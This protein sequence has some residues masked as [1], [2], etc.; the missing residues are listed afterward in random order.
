MKCW[1]SHPPVSRRITEAQS[2]ERQAYEKYEVEIA[3]LQKQQ[4]KTEN[5]NECLTTTMAT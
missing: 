5:A 3:A 4:K 1:R 2:D